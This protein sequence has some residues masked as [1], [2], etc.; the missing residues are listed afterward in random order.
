MFDTLV[1]LIKTYSLQLIQGILELIFTLIHIRHL[2][3]LFLHLC[4]LCKRKC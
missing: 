3:L 1:Y 4:P 2:E